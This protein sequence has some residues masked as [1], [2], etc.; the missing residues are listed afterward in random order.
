MPEYVVE[1]LIDIEAETPQAAALMADEWLSTGSQSGG[2]SF[3]V[4]EHGAPV[5]H[6]VDMVNA[7][8]CT[9][10][11]AVVLPDTERGWVDVDNSMCFEPDGA[12]VV[13]DASADAGD[14]A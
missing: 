13:D 1:W 11:G 14:P 9:R 4:Q 12:H 6:V 7:R 2:W 8:K 3:M 10:C 5:G